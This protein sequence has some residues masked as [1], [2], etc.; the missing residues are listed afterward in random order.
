MDIYEKLQIKKGHY[1]SVSNGPN[2]T[3]RSE[4]KPSVSEE[5]VKD[6]APEMLELIISAVFT[7]LQHHPVKY[8]SMMRAEISIIEKACYPKK[9][10]EIKKL[11]GE[12]NGN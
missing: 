8:E 11:I 9:W 5:R 6:A 7:C 2:S 3:G 12:N 10:D 4:Y 1:I